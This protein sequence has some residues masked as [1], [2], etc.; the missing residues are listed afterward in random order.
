M[1]TKCEAG[2]NSNSLEDET[3]CSYSFSTE[4]VLGQSGALLRKYWMFLCQAVEEILR[5][6]LCPISEILSSASRCPRWDLK[7]KH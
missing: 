3:K 1:Q 5:D 6:T 4:N 7:A 2:T